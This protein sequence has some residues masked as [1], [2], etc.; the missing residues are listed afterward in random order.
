MLP[1]SFAILMCDKDL[2][3]NHLNDIVSKI[4]LRRYIKY[5]RVKMYGDYDK[6][7]I[8]YDPDKEYV[9]EMARNKHVNI[10][11]K[12]EEFFGLISFKENTKGDILYYLEES[13]GNGK[14]VIEGDIVKINLKPQFRGRKV[15]LISSKVLDEKEPYIYEHF[16]LYK[17]QV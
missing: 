3:E 5:N 10:I 11:W 2:D 7:Y 14:D 13:A 17:K 6:A 8:L 9:F 16:C 4:S 1:N 12:D 15:M